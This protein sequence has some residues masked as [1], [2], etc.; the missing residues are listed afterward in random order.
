[1]EAHCYVAFRILSK[2]LLFHKLSAE[3][4][5]ILLTPYLIT[6]RTVTPKPCSAGP[7]RCNPVNMA[8]ALWPLLR[9]PRQGRAAKDRR[10]HMAFQHAAEAL[11]MPRCAGGATVLGL[12]VLGACRGRS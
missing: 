11:V 10:F 5:E 9:F 4:F 8:E 2:V 6:E 1:M 12:Y 3:I 7:T